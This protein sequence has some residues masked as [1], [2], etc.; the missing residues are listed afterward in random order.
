[1]KIFKLIIPSV[2]IIIFAFMM[3]VNAVFPEPAA[4]FYVNDLAGVLT[5]A[6]GNSI[7]AINDEL[8]G[9]GAQ[10]VVLT[11]DF[12]GGMNIADY[13]LEVFNRWEIGDRE[14]N[15]GILILLAIAEEDY[16]IATGTGIEP[17]IS[18]G[19]IQLILDRYMEPYFARN[20]YGAG[21][22]AVAREIADRLTVHYGNTGAY[23][24]QSQNAPAH[25]HLP[26]IEN[27]SAAA[28]A[29]QSLLS[30]IIVIFVIIV[31]L[32]IFLSPRQPV[33]G[34]MG[35]PMRR[36]RWFGFGGPWM[37]FGPW[38]PFSPWNRRRRSQGRRPPTGPNNRG[39]SS[40]IGRTPGGGGGR[41]SGGGAG[42]GGGFGGFGGGLGGGG[43]GGGLGRGGFGGGG[44]SGG[45]GAGRRR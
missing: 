26:A 8:A 11:V 9:G 30:T 17:V 7:L 23:L 3:S 16:Y 28:P 38:S 43:F 41:S 45:G 36:R 6:E 22:V 39:G 5:E 44:R 4:N 15:N 18:S 33:M 37:W 29:A 20:E 10:I 35:M 25:G 2:I 32:V 34:P 40:P 31:L 42:R 12:L 27:T 14:R 24:P 21:I 13:A 19:Q 1:M